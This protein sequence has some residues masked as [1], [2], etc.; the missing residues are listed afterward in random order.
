MKKLGFS[1]LALA[2]TLCLP[3]VASAA[4][5]NADR[6]HWVHGGM[7]FR[8]A[9]GSMFGLNLGYQFRLPISG[10]DHSLILGG[11]FHINFPTGTT[12]F[13]PGLDAGYRG[14]FVH[15]QPYR[16]GLIAMAQPSFMFGSSFTSIYIPVVAGGFF[17]Y[18]NFEAQ[19]T[20]GGGPAI[21]SVSVGPVSASSTDFQGT[22][23]L[24]AGY[25]F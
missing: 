15:A 21:T 20:I 17:K 19:A 7:Q 14:N 5:D 24:N 12:L 16:A 4:D 18:G 3:A 11:R 10:D 25:A 2:A 1:V 8:F 23:G 13:G 6:T 22:F 9:N